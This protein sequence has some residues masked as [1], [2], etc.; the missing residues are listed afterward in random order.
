MGPLKRILSNTRKIPFFHFTVL[1]VAMLVGQSA[2]AQG[3][4]SFGGN[5]G[6]LTW[7]WSTQASLCMETNGHIYTVH[8]TE[9]THFVYVPPSGPSQPLGTYEVGYISGS[10]GGPNCPKN[11]PTQTL[12]MNYPCYTITFTPT[13]QYG[14]GTATFTS[15]S[16]SSSNAPP[17]K[18]LSVARSKESSG[19]SQSNQPWLIVSRRVHEF[20]VQT[21]YRA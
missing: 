9:F 7:T 11:G 4:Y 16:C 18:F 14:S 10:S 1:L 8:Y 17:S 13:S 3:G 19:T 20:R 12:V 21:D 15:R 6:E 5:E 2:Y